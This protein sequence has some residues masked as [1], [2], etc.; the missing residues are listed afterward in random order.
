MAI[1]AEMLMERRGGSGRQMRDV[2]GR[3]VLHARG[4]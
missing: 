2:K 3:P 1:L 4:A